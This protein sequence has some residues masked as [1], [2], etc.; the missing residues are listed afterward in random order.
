M[1]TERGAIFSHGDTGSKAIYG[2]HEGFF[3]ILL[4]ISWITTRHH[5]TVNVLCWLYTCSS[6][7]ASLHLVIQRLGNHSEVK[8]YYPPPSLKSIM[9]QSV[10]EKEFLHQVSMIPYINFVRTVYEINIYLARLTIVLFFPSFQICN[11]SFKRLRGNGWL[12]RQRR[13]NSLCTVAS[14]GYARNLW[15]WV[16]SPV[17]PYY[18]SR[19]FI[20][21]PVL[22]G[23]TKVVNV[24]HQ[25]QCWLTSHIKL[26]CRVVANV[27][28]KSPLIP[29]HS[30]IN[31]SC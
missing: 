21:I 26:T 10:F 8:H 9:F 29:T 23:F 17:R 18:M 27:L 13:C 5:I 12:S 11:S 16:R 1:K 14:L 28:L 25:H 4:L 19:F 6:G 30:L 3:L 22:V 2:P 7:Y 20:D 31:E 24:E 15:S